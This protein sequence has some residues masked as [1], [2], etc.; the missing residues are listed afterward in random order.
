MKRTICSWCKDR[1]TCEYKTRVEEILKS[2]DNLIGNDKPICL[3]IST[4]CFWHKSAY[5]DNGYSGDLET[6]RVF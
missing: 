2:I 6:D 3:G 4:T 5:Y 1:K